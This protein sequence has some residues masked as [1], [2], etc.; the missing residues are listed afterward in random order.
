MGRNPAT[1]E[2]IRIKAS[3]KDRLPRHQGTQGGVFAESDLDGKIALHSLA[4]VEATLRTPLDVNSAQLDQP[5]PNPAE[6]GFRDGDHR[7]LDKIV[8]SRPVKRRVRRA[9]KI[10]RQ[11]RWQ[12]TQR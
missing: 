10:S 8:S 5:A 11:T 6:V 9:R 1:G 4:M 2:Q 7:N 12:P 3:K